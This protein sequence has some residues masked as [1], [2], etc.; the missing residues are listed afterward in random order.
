MKS[1]MHAKLRVSARWA[2]DVAYAVTSDQTAHAI[3]DILVD[4]GGAIENQRSVFVTYVT[5]ER[6]LCEY[7]FGGH[8]G[9]GGKLYCEDG[10][11]IRKCPW[12]VGYHPQDVKDNPAIYHSLC[13]AINKLLENLWEKTNENDGE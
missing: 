13:R 8:F 4:C 10:G 12:R 11:G 6:V 9:F 1:N 2:V 5:N 7:R 3:F